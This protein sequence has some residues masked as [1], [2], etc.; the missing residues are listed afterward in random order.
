MCMH[1]HKPK[2]NSVVFC[3]CACQFLGLP[4]NRSQAQHGLTRDAGCVLACTSGYISFLC[5]W[6]VVAACAR[7]ALVYL[8]PRAVPESEMQH[9]RVMYSRFFVLIQYTM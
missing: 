2:E 7:R 8:A 3:E 4:C 6:E 1:K 9:E 5:K